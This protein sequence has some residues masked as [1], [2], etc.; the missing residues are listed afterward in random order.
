[1]D[2]PHSPASP[3]TESRILSPAGTALRDRDERLTALKALVGQLAHDFKNLLVPQFGYVTLLKEEAADNAALAAYAEKLENSA[4]RT[5]EFLEAI[6]LAVRPQRRFAP[7]T[8]DLTA[9]IGQSIQSWQT[10]LPPSSAIQV[11]V[12]L[13]PCTLTVDE[14]H[15]RTVL[16]H[17]LSNARF[18]LPAGGTVSV[19][20]RA[21]ALTREQAA[22]LGL[23][24]TQAFEFVVRDDGIG[25]TEDLANRACEPFFT[26]RPKGHAAGLG[27]TVA[28]S[29]TH[30]HGGQ[31]LLESAPDAGTTVTIWLPLKTAL[32]AP[33]KPGYGQ[34]SA[35]RELGKKVPQILLVEGD[36]LA[37]EGIKTYLQ[38]HLACDIMIAQG[39]AEALNLL[40]KPTLDLKLVV[41]EISLPQ[42]SGLELLEK[43]RTLKP[44]TKLFLIGSSNESVPE[45][46][47]SDGGSQGPVLLRKPLALRTL[48]EAI[49]PHLQSL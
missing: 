10:S 39:A 21:R 23:S 34:R 9:L 13:E 12:E 17:L 11:R 32:A 8:A 36:P 15:W 5:E 42:G 1:M 4:R 7:K 37:R 16:H 22:T 26:T 14:K 47:L 38:Q 43:M 40:Q 41:S 31:L 46:V 19:A 28:H 44:E 45:N 33:S 49:G 20:L 2:D 18:A 3:P 6:L 25:M 29:V 48:A 35:D 24:G 27:L 30:L